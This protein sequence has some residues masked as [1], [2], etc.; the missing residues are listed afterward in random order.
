M[1]RRGTTSDDRG[2]V[3][4]IARRLLVCV[5]LM[6]AVPSRAAAGE[7]S[8]GDLTHLD[9][10][11]LMNIEVTSV[12][13]KPE[14][15]SEAA[16]ALYV[17]TGDDIQ[18]SGLETIPDALRMAPGVHVARKTANQWAVSVRGFSDQFSNKLLVLMDGRSVYTPL[19]GGVF[20]DVQDMLLEDVDRI[21]VIRGPGGTLWGANAM[22]G[23]INILSKSAKDTQGALVTAAGGSEER[24]AGAVRYGGRVG[25]GLYYRA[26][27]KYFNRDGGFV[28]DGEESDGWQMGRTGFRTDWDVSGH[29]QLTLQ[30]D[31]YEG[32]EGGFI[33]PTVAGPDDIVAGGNLLGRFTHKLERGSN[34]VLQSYYDYTYR[35]DPFFR[36]RRNTYDAELQHRVPLPF[37]QEVVWGLDY[38]VSAD[39][40]RGGPTV[41]LTADSRTIAL[42][43]AF[44]Q[45]EIRFLDDRVRFSVGTKIEH[46]DF[47]GFEYQPSARI[48]GTPLDRHTAWAAVSRAVRTPSRA[49]SDLLVNLEDPATGAVIRLFGNRRL[50]SE[51]L[52]AYEAGYRFPVAAA[53]FLDVTAFYNDYRDVLSAA[54]QSPTFDPADPGT[55]IFRVIETN[56][57]KGQIY[58]AEAAVDAKLADF[59]QLRAAYSWLDLEIRPPPG[60]SDYE[61]STNS[62]RGSSPAN[63]VSVRSLV[64][65]PYRTQLDAFFRYVDSLPSQHVDRYFSLDLRIARGFSHGFELS[66]VG[67]NLLERHHTEFTG[68]SDVERAAY[69]K[70]AWRF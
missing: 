10:E 15:N 30:G 25:D 48:A 33:D 12:S 29:D 49:E 44:L 46:N 27:A 43:S 23:V 19:F 47:T 26:Y 54:P 31:Y 40:F 36:E 39:D 3:S 66:V 34:V 45:D 41:E 20:W 42:Y 67:Q 38:R 32:R 4:G 56:H 9:L 2:P 60:E 68:G 1:P 16:A 7:E 13:K 37:H 6:S 55:P 17:I 5:V 70:I 52:L 53:L 59:W 8:S 35:D 58:G 28:P 51:K 50:D 24:G 18:R 21:E 11:D 65:L 69:G 64:N 57:T 14:K 63:Q 61:L 22:N 62:T